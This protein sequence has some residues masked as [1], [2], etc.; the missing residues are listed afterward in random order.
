MIYGCQSDVG[1]IRR[2]LIKHV[3][4]AFVSE[5]AIDA[6][7]QSLGY[8]GRPDRSRAIAEYDRFVAL[9]AQAD[10]DTCF[11]PRDGD[12]GLDSLYAR[13]ASIVCDKGVILC[14][15]GKAARHTEPNVQGAALRALDIPI[16]GAIT[17]EG[18]LEGGDVV[19][20]GARTLAVGRGYRTNDE[21]IRQLDVLL[22]GC[23]D[24]LIVV[25]LPH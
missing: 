5:E 6:Q 18:R 23:V 8:L 24:E 16:H 7:W 25:P 2:L 3:K 21:G 9:L 22:Q 14:N 13:D 20:L 1:A 19:W 10:V 17:G 11:L 12:V 4:D 15:M